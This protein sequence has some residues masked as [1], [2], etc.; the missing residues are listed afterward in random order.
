MAGPVRSGLTERGAVLLRGFPIRSATDFSKTLAGLDLAAWDDDLFRE[1]GR[2]VVSDKVF[3]TD[4]GATLRAHGGLHT[5]NCYSPERPRWIAFYCQEAPSRGGETL[6]CD[7]VEVCAQLSGRLRRKFKTASRECDYIVGESDYQKAFGTTDPSEIRSRCARSG[8]SVYQT[9]RG[10]A[11]TTRV[12]FNHPYVVKVPE[13]ERESLLLNINVWSPYGPTQ[14]WRHFR[15]RHS[16]ADWLA[17]HADY[18]SSS[19]LWTCFKHAYA[20]LH[21]GGRRVRELSLTS[22]E[23]Q[24]LGS[25]IADQLIA[26]P[27]QDGDVLLIDNLQMFHCGLLWHGARTLRVMMGAFSDP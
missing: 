16:R 15:D 11:A 7:S 20:H 13:T 18:L 4:N 27:W 26:F 3:T 5:E 6:L 17:V 10:G 2:D 24:E 25:A 19:L 1:K 14:V 21:I 23:Q 8:C 12:I 9:E 22:A